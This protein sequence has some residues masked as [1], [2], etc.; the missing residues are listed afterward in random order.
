ME[1]LIQ[2]LTYLV[3]A[4]VAAE[5]IVDILKHT[6]FCKFD[7]QPVWYQVIACVFGAFVGY[8]SPPTLPM[9]WMNQYV[10]ALVIGLAVSG[11]SG[12]WHDLLAVVQEFKKS[13]QSLNS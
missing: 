2:F 10:L 8:T 12:V 1:T 5:R 3:L 6:L 13:K 4:S 11:G 9:T 7:L